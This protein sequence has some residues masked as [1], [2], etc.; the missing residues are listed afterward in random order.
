MFPRKLWL[1]LG[2]ASMLVD[3]RPTL[4]SWTGTMFEY[5]MPALWM[6]AY[7]GSLLQQAMEGA[8]RAQQIYAAEKRIPWGISESGY[9]EVDEAGLYH[10][11]A[12]IVPELAL[13]EEQSEYLV[14]APYATALALAVD[15][16]ALKNMRRMAKQGWFGP[17][18]FYEAADF[19]PR[20]GR[21]RRR[22]FDLVKSW[23]AH[24]QGMS[25]LAIANFLENDV[26][27]QWFHRD[28]WVQA[29]EL[30]LQERSV[31]PP[32]KRARKPASR[33]RPVLVEPPPE[34][35]LAKA[36]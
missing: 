1:G 30:L 23:M 5:L 21:P 11:R 28:V 27:Q 16:A 25:L 15:P 35:K 33:R 34:R 29:T 12:F 14:V 32:V 19:T 36:S 22:R 20:M 2:R 18:G 7:R 26:V 3:G 4:L 13:Q 31:L 24:H 17:Y 9:A 10:Y 8:V 6:R